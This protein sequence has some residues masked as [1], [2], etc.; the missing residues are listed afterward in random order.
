MWRKFFGSLFALTPAQIMVEAS[1]ERIDIP[2]RRTA[3]I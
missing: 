1:Y 2:L 3:A